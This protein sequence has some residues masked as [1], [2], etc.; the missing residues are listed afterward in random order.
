MLIQNASSAVSVSRFTSDSAPVPVAAPRTETA[1]AELHQAAVNAV[2][3]QQVTHLNVPA[4]TAAQVQSAV[5]SINKAMLK[6]SSNLEFSID[7]DTKQMV[8][9]VVE[10]RT[11]DVIRQFPSEEVL[12]ISRAIDHMQQG[13]LIKQKA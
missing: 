6:N 11:G 9:K 8:V 10:S 12:A 3:E 4:P 2:A 7:H 5:D 13:F 1:P